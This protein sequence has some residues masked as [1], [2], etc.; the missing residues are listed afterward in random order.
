MFK[1]ILGGFLVLVGGFVG[2]AIQQPDELRV[3]RS[4]TMH[5]PAVVIFAQVNNQKN[6]MN[7]SPWANQDPG[8]VFG[9][10]GPEAGVGA[11]VHWAGDM[12]VGVGS[13]TIMESRPNEF[14]KFRVDFVKPME[15]TDVAEFPFKTQETNTLVT[16]TMHG[17]NSLVGKMIGMVMNCPKILGQQFDQGLANLKAIVEKK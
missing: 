8:A 7:W 17:K 12:R 1:K 2:I 5:A 9:Y 13:S 4:A 16:W 6:W 3:T 10:E 14:I 15:G 11:V